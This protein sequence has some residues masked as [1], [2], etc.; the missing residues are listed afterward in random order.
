MC[1]VYRYL[2]V[3]Y[4]IAFVVCMCIIYYDIITCK[5]KREL[6]CVRRTHVTSSGPVQ[7]LV[8][9]INAWMN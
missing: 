3:K 4:R 5:H 1:F 7:A 9:Q 2:L 8:N 6:S